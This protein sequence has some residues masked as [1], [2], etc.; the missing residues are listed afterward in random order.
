MIRKLVRLALM[1]PLGLG[2]A[3]APLRAQ[4][5]AA[6]PG[7]PR[8]AV[9]P[10]KGEGRGSFGDQ[11]DETYQKVTQ[12]F[13]VTKRFE[14]MERAQLTSVLGEAKL[15]NTGLVDDATAVA[16]GK[17][18]GV[19]FVVLGSYSGSMDRVVEHY[20]GRD[21]RPMQ[22]E[23]FP[24]AIRLNLRMVNVQSGRIEETFE[25]AG[26]SKEGSPTRGLAS[27]MKDLSVKLCRVV[28]NKFPVTG[29][30]IKV[31]S[32]KEAVI[33]L[34]QK[35]GV[36][37]GDKF[38]LVERAEDFIHPVT[39][40]TLKGHKKVITEL[41]V[42]STDEETSTVKISGKKVPLKVGLT[43]ESAP[44]KAGFWESLGDALKQ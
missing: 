26:A 17:Q 4:T 5:E 12:A 14:L 28:A 30:L 37:I 35:D 18:L 16:L 25:A 42:M 24:A 43:L 7:R 27:V 11:Q 40:K 38:V 8:I 3:Y 1:A 19:Q 13:F 10:L 33:D 15:Q 31:L 21:G 39:G 9:L 22:T 32:D 23:Y 29:Y 6:E 34:G 20:E 41:K 44:R 2:I 36:A